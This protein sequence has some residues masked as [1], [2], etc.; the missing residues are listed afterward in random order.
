[1]KLVT[2][3]FV[4]MFISSIARAD[5]VIQ[6]QAA[7]TNLIVNSSIKIHG[8][9]MREDEASQLF[10][11]FLEKRS[12]ITDLTTLKMI[13]LS[14]EDKTFREVSGET[15]K[16][17]VQRQEA[18][19]GLTNLAKIITPKP[20]DAGKAEKVGEYETEIYFWSN[21]RGMT[22]IFWVA[23][24]FPN[25]EAIKP[26]LVKLDQYH[27][28]RVPKNVMPADIGELP[29]MVVK[30]QETQKWGTY[31]VTLISA[32]IEDVEPSI[33]EVPNDYTAKKAK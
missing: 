1:M 9:K 17:F 13:S 19:S 4:A 27:H 24:N 18:K 23:K 29:G 2:A 20:S 30:N 25:F 6:E 10:G 26:Y 15:S 8:N 11:K 28:A 7:D 14:V 3:L 21:G 5:L 33:F 12:E 31:T 16:Q 32:K 22:N